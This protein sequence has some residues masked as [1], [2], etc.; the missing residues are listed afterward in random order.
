MTVYGKF[1][2]FHENPFSLLPDPNYFYASQK[3]VKALNLL[4]AAV[5][6]QS[7]FCVI[8]GEIGVGKTTILRK[9]QHR[10][11]ERVQVGL[12]FNTHSSFSDL[13]S[14]VLSAFEITPASMQGIAMYHQFVDFVAEQFSRGRLTLL[15]IDEAQNLSMPALEQLRMLANINSD[16]NQLLQII[17][18]GQ[19]ALRDMLMRPELEQLIQRVSVNYFLAPLDEVETAAYINY[20]VVHAGGKTSLFGSEACAKIY[21]YSCGIPRV[22]NYLCK[23]GLACGYTENAESISASLIDSVTNGQKPEVP[24]DED[25]TV[26]RAANMARSISRAQTELTAQAVETPMREDRLNLILS[27]LNK[28]SADIEASGVISIDG[29]MLAS[30]MPAD[31]DEDRIAAMS[32]AI[33]FLGDRTA[34]DL[35]RGVLEQVLIKGEN[36]Y[37]LMMNAGSEAAI[38]VMAKPKAR[39]GLVFLDIKRA[40]GRIA[41]LA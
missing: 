32:A 24:D 31:L 40:S 10:L 29:L 20:R 21:E 5:F 34:Q 33:L 12:I 36:G 9:L 25:S 22:I 18:V 6:R 3:H 28:S 35:G 1:Y 14:W 30:R 26:T 23:M 16:G 4:D 2:G 8:S 11:D 38:T 37:V 19:K 13:M 17:L 15:I 41:E 27:E 7:D 39:L